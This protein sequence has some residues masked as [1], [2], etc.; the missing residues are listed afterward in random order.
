MLNLLCFTK[1]KR[2]NNSVVRAADPLVNLELVLT[3][4]GQP[5]NLI[6]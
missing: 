6:E 5:G 2:V 4:M 3:I 1:K